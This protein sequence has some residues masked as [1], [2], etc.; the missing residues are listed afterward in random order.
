MIR[1]IEDIE[2]GISTR[3]KDVE[4][5]FVRTNVVENRQPQGLQIGQWTSRVKPVFSSP[6]RADS[7]SEYSNQ[8]PSQK[9][10]RPVFDGISKH[11]SRWSMA[12]S[13]EFLT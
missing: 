12:W 3:E 13:R 10:A 11:R 8:P 9:S 1:K 5:E 7:R 6:I 2:P 4:A